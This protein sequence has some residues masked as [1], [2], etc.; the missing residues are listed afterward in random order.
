MPQSR[1]APAPPSQRRRSDLAAR[2]LVG[3][4]AAVLAVVF[5]DIGGIG[6]MLLMAIL[7]CA[8][9]SE[10]YRMLEGWRPVPVVGFVV[11]VGMCFAA[12]YGTLADVVGAALVSL[13]LVFLSILSRGQSEDGAATIAATLLGVLWIGLPFAC[14]VLLRQVTGPGGTHIGK[15]ILIDVMV[16]TFVGDT[17]AYLGGRL[18]G[19]H[20]LA[21]TIS[22]KKTI[23]GLGCGALATI[24]SIVVAGLY[25][26][27]WL[28][29]STALLLGIAVAVL[30]PLGDLFESL[31]KRDIGIKDAG[32]MF[33]AHGGAL[34]RLDA[35]LFTIVVG[36][37]IAIHISH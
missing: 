4:P 34:D 24:V 13:P 15:G 17:A 23:E 20:P 2:V 31:I 8:A 29:H 19:R 35:I 25:Q 9:L 21:P 18:F 22:P 5:V 32:S 33:G 37:Y 1:R 26:Q 12:H 14:A 3:V 6:W 30:A 10:L 16:G 11:A 36:Y 28:P 27:T 7:A